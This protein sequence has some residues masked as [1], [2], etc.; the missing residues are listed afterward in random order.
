MASD[1]INQS[2]AIGDTFVV[3][4]ESFTGLGAGSVNFGSAAQSGA[5]GGR[6]ILAQAAGAA[7]VATRLADHGIGAGSY[8]LSMTYYDETDANAAFDLR[9]GG[10][11]LAS[12]QTLGGGSFDNPGLPRGPGGEAG[13]LKTL[14]F[15][16]PFV[17]DA[18]TLMTLTG[19]ANLEL[20]RVD[21][22]TFTQVALSGSFQ[23][24]LLQ[25]EAGT[26]TLA[27]APDAS[28]T[29]G[30][31]AANPEPT[32][33]LRPGFSGTGY[34]D[35]GNDAGDRASFTF[36]VPSAGNYDL[37]FRYASDSSRPIN[38]A[39]NGGTAL[40]LGFASTDTDGAGP[41]DGFNVWSFLTRTVALQAGSNTITLAIPAGATLGPNIDRI[42]VTQAGSGP[43]GTTDTSADSDNN[44]AASPVLATVP[45]SSLG[46]VG[47]RLTGVDADVVAFSAST[48]GGSTFQ[49]VTATA[50]A[51]GFRVNLD[52]SA[53]G[54]T[55]GASV[56][57]RVTDDAGNTADRTATVA[58]DNGIPSEPGP[59]N[60]IRIDFQDG[61]VPNVPGYLVANFVGFGDRGN[62]FRY[63]FV[64]EASATDAD[65]T[66]AT[67]INGAA[68]PAIAI[69]ER[70]GQGTDQTVDE[71]R[72]FDS[73][74]PRLTDYAHLDLPGFPSRVAFELG[75][76]NG[77]YEVTVA[78]GDTGGP[79]DSVNRLRI[80]GTLAS[81]YVPSDLF[82][83]ELVTAVVEVRDGF[84]TLAAPEGTVTE[85]QYLEVRNLP[86]LTPGDGRAAPLDYAKFINPVAIGGIGAGTTTIDLAPPSGAVTGV[87]PTSDLILGVQVAPDR[88]GAFL[89]SL[90]D[91]SIRLFETLT[92]LEVGF[93]TNT[94][95]GFDSLTISPTTDLRA[96]TSYTLVIDGFQDRG[97]NAS[98]SSATREFQKFT[99]TFTT[100]AAPV[101]EARDVAFTETVDVTSALITSVEFA[102]DGQH[103]YAS[104]LLGQI[105]RWDVNP[106][107][108]AL[109]N[110]QTLELSHF[111]SGGSPRGIIGLTF[112]PT[113][114]SVL[115]VTDNF[116]V[117][118]SGRDDGVPE[119][120][121]RV[122]KIT[123][124]DGPAFTGTA[125]AYVTGLPRS[126]GD[127]VTNSLEFRVNPDADQPGQPSH[128]L[129]LS[130]GS[131]TAMGETDS[132]WGFRPERLLNGAVL[133]IDPF[134][135]APTGGFNV[136]TEPLPTNGFNRRFGYQ[137]VV[138]GSLQPTDDGNLKNGG[139]AIDSGPFTGRFLHFN[140]NGVASVRETASATSAIVPNGLFYDPFAANSVVKIFATGQRNAYDL[141]WH[142]NGFL[143]APTNGSAAGGSTPDNPATPQDEGLSGV[144]VQDDYL[145]R[146][147]E[148]TY[149]GH[150]NPLRDKF[151]L[152]GGNPT[153]GADP[154]QVGAYPV[155]TPADPQYFA[156]NAYSLGRNRS[157]NGATEYTSDVFGSGLRGAVI[158]AEYSS[159]NDLRAV[160]FDANGR[161][162]DDFVLRDPGGNVLTHV[163][164]LDVVE[165][166]D[167]R[168]YLATLDRST[169]QS[170]IVRLQ[171]A[172]ANG[173]IDA[174][175][176][177]GNDLA[178]VV[179][180]ATNRSA[181]TFQVD[182]L[183]ADIVALSV[184]FNGGTARAVTLDAQRRFLVDLSGL[185]G[186]VTATLAV[187]DDAD[188]SLSRSTS[189]T[190]GAAVP[191]TTIDGV[192]FTILSTQTGAN[193]TIARRAGVPSTYEPDRAFDLNNDGLND[194]FNG[195]GYLDLNGTAETKA[196]F[197]YD[198][199]SA[200]SYLFD[201][202]LANGSAA[203]RPIAI[204]V[205][206]QTVVIDDTRTASF[207]DWRNFTVELDLQVGRN[208]IR[209]DQT[210][211]GGAPNI[212]SVVIRPEPV[213]V[214][215]FVQ[216]NNSVRIETEATDRSSRP[217]TTRLGEYYF[218]VATDGL[219]AL[220][221]AANAGSPNGVTLTLSL[222]GQVVGTEAF[223]TSGERSA[224]VELDS[225]VNYTLRVASAQPGAGS[226]D[227]VDVRQVPLL[228]NADIGIQSRD[229]AYFD[230]RLQFSYLEDPN[231]FGANAALGPRDSKTTGTVRVSNTGTQ[232]LTLLD[233]IVSGPFRILDAGALEG[234]RLAPGQFRD[235]VVQFNRPAYTPPSGNVNLVQTNFAGTVEFVTND[236]DSPR[237]T[238][239]LGGFWQQRP[240]FGL[241]PNVNEIF[242]VFGFGNRI[243][244]LPLRN[245][246][247][248]SVLDTNDVFGKVDETEVLSPYWR[249]AD[250]VTN[251]RMTHLAAFHGPD[252]AALAI[253][254]PGNKSSAVTLSFQPAS[255]N[256]VILPNTSD[257]VSFATRLFGDSSIPDSW[258]GNDIFGIA[259]A[260][261]SSDPRLNP[262]GPV[263]VS[264]GGQFYDKLSATTA[265][266][267]GGGPVVQISS[268]SLV[269]QGHTVKIFQ[270]L[271][272]DGNAISNVFIGL[273]DYTGIN[274]DYNDN[275]FLIEGV[276]PVGFGGVLDILGLDRPAAADARLV[277]SRIE[278][279][280]NAQQRFH[281]QTVIT[282]SN[283]GSAAVSLG[284][285]A[286]S[287]A[288]ASAFQVIGSVPASIAAGGSV[289]VTVRFLG[290]DLVSDNRATSYEAALSVTSGDFTRP[291][292]VIQ[293]AGIAQ[294]R[295]EGGEEPTVQQIVDAFGYGTNIA[296]A[297]LA[298]GGIVQA[299]GDEVL[300]PYLE[301]LDATKSIEVIQLGAYLNQGNIARLGFHRVGNG[302]TTQMLANDDQQG[303]TLLPD[304]LVV[305][306]GDTGSVARGAVS[307]QAPFGLRVTVDGRPT[308][309]SWSDPEAN[310]IDPQFGQIVADGRGH[311]IR[312][313]QAK[314]AAGQVI[315][316][317]FIGIQDYPGG[318]NF[319]YNDLVFVI[320][321]VKRHVLTVAEDANRDGINDALR[322]DSD[323]D[324][325]VNFFD[326]NALTKGAYVV[327]YNLGGG[328]VASQQGLGGVALRSETD[329]RITLSGDA[330]GRSVQFD[331]ASNLNG[332]NALAGAF[333]TYRDGKSWSVEVSGLRD[334]AYVVGLHTQETFWNG[335]GKRQ[336][337]VSVNG[338]LVAND[339]D[340]F[341]L[342]GAGDK[343]IAF[344]TAV[345]V[346]GGRFTVTLD[347]LGSDGI[348]F[349]PLNA[350]TVHAAFGNTT[351]GLLGLRASLPVPGAPA[352]TIGT[353]ARTIDASNYDAGGQGVAYNDTPGLQGTGTIDNGRTGSAVE[354]TVGGDITQTAAGEWL[355]YSV[356]VATA[357]AYDLDLLLAGTGAGRS[358][359]VDFYKAG[360]SIAYTTTGRI[361]APATGSFASFAPRGVDAL[362]LDAGTQVVRVNFLGGDQDFRSFTLTKVT[363]A[364]S[365]FPGPTA[366][367]LVAGS[368]RLD[369][370]N[371]DLGGQGISFN[372]AAGLQGGTAGG[373]SDGRVEHT[374]GGDI[375]FSAAGDWLEYSF[376][377][378]QG[379]SH[380][381]AVQLST[382]TAGRQ[383]QVDFFKPGAATPYESTGVLANA[384][385]GSLATFQTR[386]FANLDLD[387]G[388]QALRVTFV[389]GAQDFRS[390]TLTSDALFLG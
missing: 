186:P 317:T 312:L 374:A 191:V 173:A 182:G 71:G 75:L 257:N 84:L 331:D 59:R 98:T 177:E 55:N 72:N 138:G 243:E 2:A 45:L 344:E 193:Q 255:D 163:D 123:I 104:T 89:G 130:Q 235:V 281:D 295:S 346:V 180:N 355:E 273:M 339:A 240:E 108:G 320:T 362:F 168:L 300:M 10:A 139:I 220:D 113:N 92:G 12:A 134:R 20:L 207:T 222:N 162:R 314:D 192:A 28:S 7:S 385:T 238:V 124:G 332:A 370:S 285:L 262:T 387:A 88:G 282:L 157:P 195:G 229:P 360:S 244:D 353:A 185:T 135:T 15:A 169:G 379:G 196:S 337:D 80:E 39:V 267:V 388:Q 109:S 126:N 143:Y 22:F 42:E 260:G 349:A 376:N 101:I 77:W 128:L 158:F 263:L 313:F 368:L 74:D 342:A 52:L 102:P 333:K 65:G 106:T 34:L 110:E 37:N 86:D 338:V 148:G 11:V 249:I 270:A 57:L 329:Q 96:F 35:Y 170:L 233:T 341:V 16:T 224:F 326:T 87:D 227:Y 23:P 377:L 246:G 219:Y 188:N 303:Q 252:G 378:A 99:T 4:A 179:V 268:L 61:T 140:A 384:S 48:N 205:G 335:P 154:N 284:G 386:S 137:T 334:G 277:F 389:N 56:V 254:A 287:G 356:N 231:Y 91:G 325:L 47:F 253:H 294:N 302:A 382:A 176:D 112:D 259:M 150:P 223:P 369:A 336:F 38:L 340:P 64:T 280:A 203:T 9:V 306:A 46:S 218:K 365:P 160:L 278:T 131:N 226:L 213:F 210:G 271:D 178:L 111:T 381:L 348:D 122:S 167:G 76:A 43:I 289:N 212:D 232:E 345:N 296:Q 290:R 264:T 351:G 116:P 159:G 214:P 201:F 132:A 53:F 69:N 166:A 305:G 375:G 286:L 73:Y 136:A 265:R 66:R 204:K 228:A 41:V 147:T 279:P 26:I 297:Q 100:K 103:L 372:D 171:P 13:N 174:T 68:F 97:S 230:N 133:E 115:W 208:T 361:D 153:S 215:N 199:L 62:G 184:A 120:S 144:P 114:P 121:G 383:F 217:I 183:D 239:D 293:L 298:N 343:P 119:F 127:H 316:G 151:I 40:S 50:V 161:V 172:P 327:G 32:G 366:P 358:V 221:F 149:S 373:R 269:Q 189:F 60:T 33:V 363:P 49:A 248:N 276:T 209:I 211:A 58:I 142:S 371:Y 354:Q 304:G 307:L 234:L 324:G 357:G 78:V 63:G 245:G 83:T 18:S 266:L 247:E 206:G 380:D 237:V 19:T 350:I 309:A 1:P 105:K 200:G 145:F 8:R 367:S 3:E 292:Q 390:V 310:E 95:A 156:A 31:S 242:E 70:T 6:L 17:V 236:Q 261:L 164:P 14:T 216:V 175:A 81:D 152:N 54:S 330:P 352:P 27:Q 21:R 79:N 299:I 318:G 93:S 197:T 117:P 51:G 165:G 85:L 241:E 319:D 181:V 256:Q 94:T 274:Y 141:V 258:I 321:N 67:P 155:G 187:R 24:L 30:R 272:G 283:P 118:L 82:K 36:T 322:T 315:A 225:G 25:A 347:A 29:Q 359:R 90:T 288:D 301:R 44:L 364:Q 125:S 291:V 250:G 190:P 323:G 311:L 198:V 308:Y 146:I 5:S 275:V 251:I 328:A 202:R 129:Y 107:T 194:G